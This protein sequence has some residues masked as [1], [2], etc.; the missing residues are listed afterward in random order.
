MQIDIE[1][2]LLKAQESAKK[3]Y[4]AMNCCID[5]KNDCFPT[6]EVVNKIREQIDCLLNDYFDDGCILK[7]IVKNGY[8]FSMVL[9]FGTEHVKNIEGEQYTHRP[10][11]VMQF[12]IDTIT[13]N[14]MLPFIRKLKENKENEEK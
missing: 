6:K 2:Q 14:F 13:Y 12:V 7:E 4:N 3:L 8:I 10:Q 9:Y 11:E 5:S 1:P